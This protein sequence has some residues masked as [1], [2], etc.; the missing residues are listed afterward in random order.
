MIFSLRVRPEVLFARRPYVAES[1]LERRLGIVPDA[2]EHLVD[3]C[4]SGRGFGSRFVGR[5][6]GFVGVA[7]DV[8]RVLFAAVEVHLEKNVVY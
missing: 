6:F 4:Q 3:V 8:C 1:A 2:G 5:A 7:K